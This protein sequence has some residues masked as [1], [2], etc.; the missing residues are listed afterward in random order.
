MMIQLR[1]NYKGPISLL[2]LIVGT[3]KASERGSGS[4]CSKGIRLYC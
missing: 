4:E 3:S 2:G 1:A